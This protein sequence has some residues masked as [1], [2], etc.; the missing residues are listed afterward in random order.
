ME[1]SRP[2]KFGS[3]SPAG[4]MAEH[5]YDDLWDIEKPT[6]ADRL[7]AAP[8]CGQVALVQALMEEIPEPFGTLYVLILTRRDGHEAGRYQCPSPRSR[9]ETVAF[10]REYQEYF[11]RDGRH[12]LWITSV[13]LPATIVYDHHNVIYAYGPTNAIQGVVQS[14]GLTRGLFRFPDPHSHNYNAE[15]DATE[16][17]LLAH[18]NWRW[19]PLHAQDDR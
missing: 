11:E 9:E 4:G 19:S 13:S 1:G 17:R 12:H 8:S 6:G 14:R 7:I 2:F 5:R 16:D 10:L 3:M 15:Y 18:W